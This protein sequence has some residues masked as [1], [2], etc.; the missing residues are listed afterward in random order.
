[1]SEWIFLRKIERLNTATN[2]NTG[3]II[4]SN[5]GSPDSRRVQ[6]CILMNLLITKRSTQKKNLFD[7]DAMQMEFRIG[8]ANTGAAI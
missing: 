4:L 1:M 6:F 2:R 5:V 7:I 8:G 3:S